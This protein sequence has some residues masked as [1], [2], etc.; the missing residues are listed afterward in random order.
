MRAF[1][2]VIY[3]TVHKFSPFL[4]L[5]NSEVL[6]EAI[7]HKSSHRCIRHLFP[8]RLQ[9]G[10]ALGRL[11]SVL[12]RSSKWFKAY[13][14]TGAMSACHLPKPL[15][16]CS[17]QRYKS[18]NAASCI[19]LPSPS[20]P[21]PIKCSTP[22]KCPHW[23]HL[24]GPVASMKVRENVPPPSAPRPTQTLDALNVSQVGTRRTNLLTMGKVS[25]LGTL[26]R[27]GSLDEGERKCTTTVSPMPP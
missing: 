9:T 26:N 22:S 16:N 25:P 14:P 4:R 12:S 21:E 24:T 20:A 3:S 6:R 15:R 2:C 10:L 19:P 13:W 18:P 27:A 5:E 1:V 7:F 17:A 23:G 11:S 8:E